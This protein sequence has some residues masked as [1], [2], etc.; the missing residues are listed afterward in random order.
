MGEPEKW[1]KAGTL[2]GGSRRSKPSQ[3]KA[4]CVSG[5]KY[6]QRGGYNHR[7][8]GPGIEP[9]AAQALT[10]AANHSLSTSTW[11]SYTSV[12]RQ[13]GKLAGELG[14]TFKLPMTTPMVRGIVGLLIRKGRKS[15]TILS[16]MASLKKAHIIQ[17]LDSSAL[18]DWIVTAAIKGVKNRESLSLT[19][20]PVMTM[21]K[22]GKLRVALK[23][24]K[25]PSRKKKAIW[26]AIIWLFMGS[27]RG[28][29]ILSP[30]KAKF[31]PNKTMLHR[32]VKEVTVKT[33]QEE[34]K[35]IQLKL[36]NPKTSR[37]QPIQVV[38]LPELGGWLCPV[39][40]YKDWQKGMKGKKKTGSKPLFIWDDDTLITLDEL[41][42][43]LTG[44]LPEE[45]P[46]MTSRAFRPALPSI[47]A[48][49]G[50]SEDLLRSLGRWTSQTYLTYVREGR[51]GDWRSLLTSL[52]NLKL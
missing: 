16:Y 40:A 32:D 29:E 1:G 43:I 21:E 7:M 39:Q 18:Q 9:R 42:A 5:L 48:R 31:D 45:D 49:Q 37:S 28:S 35:T 19:P 44:L 8:L 10:E 2:K 47:L 12:W 24:M 33:G 13:V 38:E 6:S 27:M 20:R 34:V 17:G 3:G 22:L 23:K 36:K 15:G 4:L 11:C 50:A 41:N 30:S 51:T 52:H 14:L 26:T 25:G 46:A